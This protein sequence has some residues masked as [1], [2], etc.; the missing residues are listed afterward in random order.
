[1]AATH[2]LNSSSRQGRRSKNRLFRQ[3]PTY[4]YIHIPYL[5]LS[6][7]TKRAIKLKNLQQYTCPR[8]HDS[9]PSSLVPWTPQFLRTSQVHNTCRPTSWDPWTLQICQKF[10]HKKTRLMKPGYGGWKMLTPEAQETSQ[11]YSQLQ[12][13]YLIAV[14]IESGAGSKTVKV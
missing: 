10:H 11:P 3:K 9:S 1:M 13:S 2:N 7:S 12:I 14:V 4:V 6:F 8:I 5:R